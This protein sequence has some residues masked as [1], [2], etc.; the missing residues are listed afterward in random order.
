MLCEK[1]DQGFS[2]TLR[3]MPSSGPHTTRQKKNPN[4][5]LGR[6]ATKP[7]IPTSMS[8]NEHL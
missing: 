5:S 4:A 1:K 8:R 6:K 3:Y 7:N 2:P